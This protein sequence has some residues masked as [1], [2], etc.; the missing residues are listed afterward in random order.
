MRAND[1]SALRLS[2]IL[3]RRQKF[4]E[5]ITTSLGVNK[6]VAFDTGNPSQIN[7]IFLLLLTLLLLMCNSVLFVSHC[8]TL[9]VCWLLARPTWEKQLPE[10]RL[11]V[12]GI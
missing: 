7:G 3:S 5:I 8:V 10:K 4:Y 9:F 1:A 6:S 12:K 11:R 2:F